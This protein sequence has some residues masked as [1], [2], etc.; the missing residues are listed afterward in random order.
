MKR[1]KLIKDY[2]ERDTA[3]ARKRIPDSETAIM[4]ELKD[5]TTTENTGATTRK[6]KTIFEKMLYGIG[7]SLSA[8][9]YSDDEQ[10]GEVEEVDGEDTE[11]SKVSN[12][13]ERHLVMGTISKTVQHRIE[14]CRQKQ[15][16]LDELTQAGWGG[17]ANYFHGRDM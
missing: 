8:L 4:Q 11:L 12:D 6:P 9:A 7:D 10:D 13:D 5:M 14:S 1:K 16:I 17:T 2:V 3:V 15:M